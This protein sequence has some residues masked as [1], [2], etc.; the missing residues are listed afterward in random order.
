[1]L[2]DDFASTDYE[3]IEFLMHRQ[4]GT[5]KT[6]LQFCRER[7]FSV[8]QMMGQFDQWRAD[9]ITI[10]HDPQ[11]SPKFPSRRFLTRDRSP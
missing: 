9:R 11:D 2:K 4:P 10:D 6:W 5:E 7:D 8:E 3:V 1:M